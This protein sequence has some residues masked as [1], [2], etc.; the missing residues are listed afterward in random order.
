MESLFSYL[1]LS[2]PLPYGLAWAESVTRSTDVL[3]GLYVGGS[4]VP[5][6]LRINYSRAR[7]SG[8]AFIDEVMR[9]VDSERAMLVGSF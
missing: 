8:Q 3:A 5:V 7:R 9:C 6:R 2:D 4:V 1:V